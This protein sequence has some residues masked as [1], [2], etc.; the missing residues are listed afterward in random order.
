MCARTARTPE[1]PF[2]RGHMYLYLYVC[3]YVYI[4]IYIFMAI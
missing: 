1:G 3:A 4:Y 2:F